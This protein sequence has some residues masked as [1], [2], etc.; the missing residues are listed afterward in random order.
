MGTKQHALCAHLYTIQQER[1]IRVT[2]AQAKFHGF[3]VIFKLSSTYA[4][5]SLRVCVGKSPNGRCCVSTAESAK[6]HS[7][8]LFR[9]YRA[10]ARPYYYSTAAGCIWEFS[11]C[12]WN[13]DAES[14][15]AYS[16]RPSHPPT[17]NLTRKC[18]H[19]R[20][21]D[22]L[23]TNFQSACTRSLQSE[24]RNALVSLSFAAQSCP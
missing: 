16:T 6:T 20:V 22:T 17:Y 9:K 21:S 7:A 5:E 3:G 23:I 12:D 8:R 1:C 24:E 15:N 14:A 2:R 10:R 19:A 11:P 18:S 4:R 13:A